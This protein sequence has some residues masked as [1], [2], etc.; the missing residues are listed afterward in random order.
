MK[1]ENNLTDDEKSEI[2]KL[3]NEYQSVVFSIGE[4]SIKKSQLQ[5][6]LDDIIEDETELLDSFE[7]MKRKESDFITRIQSKY[8]PGQLDAVH[9]KYIGT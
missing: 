6:E 7:G 1:K 2:T 9:G 3:N 8:G 4:L 5:K